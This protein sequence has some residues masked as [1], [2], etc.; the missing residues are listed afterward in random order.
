[1]SDGRPKIVFP[2][3]YPIKILGRS[4]ENL[5]SSVIAVLNSHAIG[6]DPQEVGIKSSRNGTFQSITVTL[7]AESENQIRLIYKDL[8]ETGLVSM[9]M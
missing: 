7:Q 9:V 4:H 1:M 5:C 8:M 2:C 3:R 6:F